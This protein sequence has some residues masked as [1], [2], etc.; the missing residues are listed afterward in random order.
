DGGADPLVRA[1][2]EVAGHTGG[3]GGDRLGGGLLRPAAQGGRQ[4]T[5]EGRDGQDDRGEQVEPA[6]TPAVWTDEV[7]H[8]ASGAAHRPPSGGV[9]ADGAGAGRRVPA[10]HTP[11]APAGGEAARVA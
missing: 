9:V 4:I 10:W 3:P 7:V 8:G 6:R 5:G 2:A 11:P 1:L